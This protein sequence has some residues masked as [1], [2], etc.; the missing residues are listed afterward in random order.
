LRT[1]ELN[2][3]AEDTPEM[4]KL[5][6]LLA[7]LNAAMVTQI[8]DFIRTFNNVKSAEFKHFKACLDTI[9]EFKETGKNLI[10]SKKEETGYKMIQFMKKTMRSVTREFPNIVINGVKYDQV[11]V[12]LHW[13]LS[14]I[15]Q[16]N[17]RD[18]IQGHYS[19]L[20]VFYADA[21]I[22]LL[23]TKMMGLTSEL[24]E[25]AQNTLCYAPVELPAKG[26]KEKEKEKEKEVKYSAF[27]LD[28]TT[29]LFKFYFFSALTELIGLQ[30]D[31]EILGLPL[32]QVEE[33]EAEDSFL[34]KANEME[35]LAGNQDELG[36]KIAAL[37]VTFT[38]LICND[39][40]AI[41]YN[42][43]GLMELIL[44]SKEREKKEITDYLGAMTIEERAIEDLFKTNKLE[45]WSKGQ[46]KGIHTYVGETYDEEMAALAKM[47][48]QDV[49]KADQAASDA[50]LDQEDQHIT[51]MG[52][53][54]EPEEYEMDGDENY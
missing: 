4:Y 41:D 32:K 11:K 36:E 35:I 50:A 17:V 49:D 13:E 40:S 48:A 20:A 52:E 38:N 54:A 9:V 39:K 16:K 14:M 23:M 6:N 42:Y 15:H 1:F 44:R 22:Q 47:T 26:E 12:P 33:N 28:L 2:A 34:S 29:L 3:L 10:L 27:D 18:M 8:T 53:D 51:Y 25:L 19:D 7:K 46:Q 30:K 45:R 43:K 24:N 21:Q 31:K 37:I 5:K